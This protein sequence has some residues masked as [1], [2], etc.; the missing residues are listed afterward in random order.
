MPGCK[1]NKLRQCFVFCGSDRVA[2]C[3]R[4]D[5]LQR[6]LGWAQRQHIGSRDCL[7]GRHC[8]PLCAALFLVPVVL[9]HPPD[10]SPWH[11]VFPGLL[12]PRPAVSRSESLGGLK[13]DGGRVCRFWQPGRQAS[14]G[15]PGSATLPAGAHMQRSYQKQFVSSP[16]PPSLVEPPQIRCGATSTLP[17]SSSSPAPPTSRPSPPPSSPSGCAA[18]ALWAACS[19]VESGERSTVPT[20]MPP[21][22][23]PACLPVCLHAC[24]QAQAQ[25]RPCHFPGR[26][27]LLPLHTAHAYLPPPHPTPPFL[28]PTHRRGRVLVIFLGG[29]A[30]CLAAGLQ[31][32]SQNLAM[33]YSG[34]WGVWTAGLG[35]TGRRAE[36]RWGVHPRQG[37]GY[38]PSR[39]GYPS[40]CAPTRTDHPPWHHRY[41]PASLL[42]LP[43][44]PRCGGHRH[45]VRQPGGPRECGQAYASQGPPPC[46]CSV[47]KRPRGCGAAVHP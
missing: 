3:C 27:S 2:G 39:A 1:T 20:P 22:R 28:P 14:I 33:L 43:R 38:A 24:T 17:R 29:A 15:R 11:A 32:G 41:R 6:Q 19:G 10:A 26:R 35:L 46:C 16:T 23:P 7:A 42:S 12:F 13:G 31:S 34:G 36:L 21:A 5:P 45:G 4:L 40:T 44:R 30:Y 25:A 37:C 9:T 8:P 47:C 18:G